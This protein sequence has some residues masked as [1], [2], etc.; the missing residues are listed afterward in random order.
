LR[1]FGRYIDEGKGVTLLK[2]QL[3]LAALAELRIGS[4][5]ARWQL[6]T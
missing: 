3:A 5:S 2:A 4:D 1:W 6:D